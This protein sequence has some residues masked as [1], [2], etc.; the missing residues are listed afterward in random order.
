ME[1]NALK[2]MIAQLE[3]KVQDCKGEIEGLRSQIAFGSNIGLN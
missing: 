3:L 1:N 2:E